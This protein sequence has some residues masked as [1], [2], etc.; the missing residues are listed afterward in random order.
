MLVGKTSKSGN[1]CELIKRDLLMKINVIHALPKSSSAFGKDHDGFSAAMNEIAK[2]HDVEWVNVH[3]ANDDFRRQVDRIMRADF[4]LVR[5][6]WGWYPDAISASR[7]ARSGVPC[8]L[9]V[10]GSHKPASQLQSLRYDVVFYETPWYSQ[11]VA[12]H[13]FAVKAFGIDT[14][15]MRDLHMDRDIDWLFVGRLA[16]FKR[17]LRLLEKTG[18]RVVVGDL[19]SA[20]EGLKEAL[21]A[22]G[23]ELVDH[24]S[25]EEL[26]RYYNR[27]KCVLV[28]CELQGGGERAVLEAR[29]CGCQ[30]EIADDNPKL[31][32]LLHGPV[33]SHLDYARQLQEAIEEVMAG[34][35]VDLTLKRLGE[36]ERERDVFVDKA[37]RSPHTIQLRTRNAF[38]RWRDG[39]ASQRG[40]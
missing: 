10:A 31:A 29:L 33:P 2:H 19:A 25:Q 26:G 21:I 35:R 23:V 27:S 13:P 8:G 28:P 15:A 5:S 17:P 32:S 1:P 22:D 18:R 3:P 40:R 11:F 30:V 6:D 14:S 24:V 4:V 16:K 39:G 7:L 34:H 20:N 12:G 9:V 36:L 38:R 37:R